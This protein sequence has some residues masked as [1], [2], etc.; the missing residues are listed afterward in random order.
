MPLYKIT[1]PFP[2]ATRLDLD[3]AAFRSLSC[4]PHHPGLAWL[5]SFWNPATEVLECIYEST[6]PEQI[7]RHA[8]HAQLPCEEIVE[9]EEVLPTD[10]TGEAETI[11]PRNTRSFTDE[12]VA[13]RQT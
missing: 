9:I 3:A 6:G 8:Q 11:V 7:R 4:I 13:P 12:P 1:R 2:G 5:R 10:F